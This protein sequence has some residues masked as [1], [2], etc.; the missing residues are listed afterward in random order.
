MK[1]LV[2]GAT[3]HLGSNLVRS[4]IAA[5]D[6]V[7]ALARASSDRRG[8]EGLPITIATGDLLDLSSVEAAAQGCQRIFHAGAVYRNFAVDPQTIIAPALEGTR[9]VMKAAQ[10]AR[11]EK[12]IYT[13]SNATIG[14]GRDRATPLDESSHLDD[15]QSPYIR[16]KILAERA[17]LEAGRASGIPVIV[18]CPV[19]IF[20]RWDFRLTPTTRALL[21]IAEK[22]PMVLDLCAT[23]VR[24]VA[25]AHILAATKGRAYERYLIGGD[26]LTREEGARILSELVGR[27]V[28]A[29]KPPMFMFRLIA[30]M[31][32]RKARR[33]GGDA[34]ITRAIVDDVGGGHLMYSSAKARSE[35][36][37]SP[38]GAKETFTDALRWL[39]Y[40]DALTP[41]TRARVEAKVGRFSP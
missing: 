27:T 16:A 26:N 31:E 21:A 29:M 10:S 25:H 19:G 38:R 41:K 5:G 13:S 30:W 34:A 12:V 17:A 28:K 33:T 24:D 22:D 36:G 6:E 9:N 7:V 37:F 8:L 35:L 1:S 14:Y 18:L 32:E 11:V 3:G 2:T 23:D 39:V 15:A 20:G 40:I 4:L